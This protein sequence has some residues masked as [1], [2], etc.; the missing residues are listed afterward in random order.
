M[1]ASHIFMQLKSIALFICEWKTMDGMIVRGH[2]QTPA[3]AGAGIHPW[4]SH[5]ET[6][7]ST[8]VCT[9]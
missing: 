9:G 2:G 8:A 5:G 4:A 7:L 6:G 1:L 3:A